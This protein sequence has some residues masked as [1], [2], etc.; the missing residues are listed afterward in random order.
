LPASRGDRWTSGRG[1]D[2]A[3]EAY[4]KLSAVV[5]R[6]TF[7]ALLIAG[8]ALQA[9]T[10][11]PQTIYFDRHGKI[12]YDHVGSYVSS[13]ELGRDINRYGLG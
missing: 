11:Y 3:G 2:R 1:I 9:A 8:T 7:A 10:Y 5:A 13:A 6:S 4:G 12:V